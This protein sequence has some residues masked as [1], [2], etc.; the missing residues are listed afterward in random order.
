MNACETSLSLPSLP[1]LLRNPVLKSRDRSLFAGRRKG[2]ERM[3]WLR[4]GGGDV[5]VTGAT[6]LEYFWHIVYDQD[7]TMK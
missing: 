2:S 6:H 1:L 3:D 7:N 4:F 5:E